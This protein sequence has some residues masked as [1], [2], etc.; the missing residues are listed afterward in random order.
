MYNNKD[1][2]ILELLG[3]VDFIKK[4]Y[5]ANKKIMTSKAINK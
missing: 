2:W 5:R 3:H 1:L 4:R